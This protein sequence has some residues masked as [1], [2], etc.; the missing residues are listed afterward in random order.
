MNPDRNECSSEF[1]EEGEG[2]E[3][4]RRAR[5]LWK[6]RIC[7]NEHFMGPELRSRER[8]TTLPVHSFELPSTIFHSFE[9]RYQSF[10]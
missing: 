5:I 8:K 1:A 2:V 10:I 4:R 9:K 3:N 6:R 7:R